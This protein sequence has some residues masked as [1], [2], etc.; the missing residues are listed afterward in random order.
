MI[1]ATKTIDFFF[2]IVL[3][4]K[5][6]S[7][8]VFFF[9]FKVIKKTDLSSGRFF[10]SGWFWGF[11]VFF[12]V[13][14]LV[15]GLTRFLWYFLSVLGQNRL[16]ISFWIKKTW[17]LFFCHHCGWNLRIQRTCRLVFFIRNW[18]RWQVWPWRPTCGPFLD[19][20]SVWLSLPGSTMPGFILFFFFDFFNECLFYMSFSTYFLSL[21]F[22]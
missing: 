11:K 12:Y 10:I 6:S 8:L 13:F 9:L 14:R 3:H 15:I 5:R 17:S 22:N 21:C 4:V 18:S 19:R 20:P 1:L 2:Q 7:N 16:K